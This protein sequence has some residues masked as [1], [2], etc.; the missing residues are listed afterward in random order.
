[1]APSTVFPIFVIC[2]LVKAA[3]QTRRINSTPLKILA[4]WSFFNDVLSQEDR[5][6]F[7]SEESPTF[8][9]FEIREL[10]CYKYI[11]N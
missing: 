9:I 1:M 3:T 10:G 11:E 2:E 7:L 8:E 4:Y 6:L 5:L